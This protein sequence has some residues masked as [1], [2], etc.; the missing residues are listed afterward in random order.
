MANSG[1]DSNNS[2]TTIVLLNTDG[3]TI[4]PIKANPTSHGIKFDDGAGGS[5]NGGHISRD[6]NFEPVGAVQSS[7]G[8]GTIIPLYAD[9]SGKLFIKST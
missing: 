8:D 3:V 6:E 5:D 2:H 4:Q 1:I 9:S 7:A